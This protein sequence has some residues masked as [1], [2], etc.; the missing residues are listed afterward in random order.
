MIMKHIVSKNI[1]NPS[2]Q[3]YWVDLKENPYGGVI[4]YYDDDLHRWVYLDEPLFQSSA[5]SKFT[6]NHLNVIEELGD[7]EDFSSNLQEQIN[8]LDDNKAD[9]SEIISK[10][11]V[12]QIHS[13]LTTQINKNTGNIITVKNTL[14]VS[15][16]DGDTKNSNRIEEV[17]SALTNEINSLRDSVQKGY[18][19]TELRNALAEKTSYSYVEQQIQNITGVP[20]TILDTLE[21]LATALGNDPNFATTVTELIGT[22]TTRNDVVDIV[23]DM[24]TDAGIVET[25]PT[26]PQW[27]KQSTKPTYTA[28]EVGALPT[29]T[30]I[31]NKTTDLTNDAGFITR[32]AVNSMIS[33][34]KPL[35]TEQ[36]AKINK[37]DSYIVYNL[38]EGSIS[39]P[40][41]YNTIVVNVPA[42]ITEL[43][44]F[45]FETPIKGSRFRLYINPQGSVST[46]FYTLQNEVLHTAKVSTVTRFDIT[47]IDLTDYP[48][49]T[50]SG[51]AIVS[52]GDTTIVVN[53]L[54][55]Y[56]ID[57]VYSS[58]NNLTWYEGE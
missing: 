32:D 35:T 56:I 22:K 48:M 57:Y 38:T 20:P 30:F 40:V 24:L 14:A 53:L 17:N 39:L 31:P 7:Y 16:Q 13:S 25:D 6:E 10:E 28:S 12:E 45:F 15:I 8:N 5:A 41:E 29:T 27:A 33:A 47:A 23:N 1:P 4:K 9:R 49:T 44:V 37:M 34:N 46:N 58:S 51:M 3:M 50:E 43:N 21:E 2:E 42:D 52:E 26:V 55:G 19:D 54:D 36:Y 18:D 11:D